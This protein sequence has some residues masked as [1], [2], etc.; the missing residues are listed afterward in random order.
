VGGQRS[1]DE[2]ERPCALTVTPVFDGLELDVSRTGRL[3]FSSSTPWGKKTLWGRRC[4]EVA[5][6]VAT[7]GADGWPEECCALNQ[8]LI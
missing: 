2:G 8:P 4:E 3:K 6:K 5:M 7:A 1:H